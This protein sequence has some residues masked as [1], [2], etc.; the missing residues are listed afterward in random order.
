VVASIALLVVVGVAFSVLLSAINDL[1]G[2]TRWTEHSVAVLAASGEL[3]NDLSD[4]SSATRNYIDSPGR[5]ALQRFETLRSQ[6]PAEANRLE[7]MVSDNPE[8][9]VAARSLRTDIDSFITDYD[10]PLMATA[11]SPRGLERARAIVQQP[12]G[13]NMISVIR[14]EFER[15]NAHEKSLGLARGSNSRRHATRAAVI[16]V[17]ALVVLLLAILAAALLVGRWVV[18]PLRRMAAAAARLGRGDLS[19]RVDEGGQGEVRDLGRAFNRMAA[20]VRDSRDE[21]ETQN[22]ELEAQQAELEGALEQLAEEKEQVEELR[23]FIELISGE[24]DPDRLADTVLTELAQ[25]V[26]AP[27]GTLYGV[28]GE[29]GATLTCLSALGV[30][31]AKLPVEILPGEGFAGRA[32]VGREIVNADFGLEGLRFESFGQ[33]VTLN[34]EVHIP[35]V[36][37]EQTVGVVTL[38]RTGAYKLSAAELERIRYLA[39][40]AAVGLSHAFA[41]RRA[42]NQAALN[43]AVLDSAY[44]AVVSFD[45]RGIVT[46]WN[47]RAELIFGW[48]ALEALGREVDHLIVPEAERGWYRRSL[49]EFLQGGESDLLN[50]R[51]EVTGR[52]RGGREFPAE[53]ALSA[54]ELDG[55]WRFNAFI[56]DISERRQLEERSGRLFSI[57]LDFMATFTRDGHLR[58]INPA[59]SKVLGWTEEE[60]LGSNM[61]EYVHP[62]DRERTLEQA[63]RLELDGEA[64]AD[65]EN[66]WRCADGSY[67]WM[68]WSARYSRDE[69]LIYAVAKDVT[70]AKRNERFF[71][72]RLAVSEAL[73][74]ADSLEQDLAGAVAAAGKS[75]GWE[76]A[77]AWIPT[78]EGNAMRCA[79]VWGAEGQDESMLSAGAAEAELRPG[80]GIVG[81]AWQSG[82]PVWFTDAGDLVDDPSHPLA[83]VLRDAGV[84]AV[85]AVPL[86]GEEGVVAVLQLLSHATREAD[87]DSLRMLVALGE[88]VGHAVYRRL[89]RMEADRMKDE[90]L[91]LVS[92]ELRTPLTSIVGYLELLRDDEDE[93]GT[94]QGQRFLEVIERNATRLQ[95]LVDDVLFAARAEAGRMG[96][97]KRDIN[98][99]EVIE[100][101][102]TAAGPKAEDSGVLVH[103]EV[104]RVPRF[105]GDPDRLGQ[106]LDNLISNALKFTPP[107][108][109][110][111]V[112]LRNLGERARIEVR[113]T[114]LGMAEED[115]ARAFDRFFRASATRDHAPGVGLGLTIVKTIVEGHG[116]TIEVASREGVGTAFT[117]ELPLAAERSVSRS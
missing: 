52:H 14:S 8:Q 105:E 20:S 42:R 94:E 48:T 96:L 50:R 18:A 54:V 83:P 110:V 45:E 95:R 43:R 76:F 114:G 30:D 10:D 21:L 19:A 33:V 12:T 27:V 109:R 80:E 58:Q 65:F 104:E 74:D 71:Q 53:F 77:A 86:V 82:E 15:F 113:D 100:E 67:R 51:L 98:L 78:E 117:I 36:H 92:H 102:V 47:P 40:Q 13:R 4:F 116:G 31:L 17:S 35:L 37:G 2:S 61:L 84:R 111:D 90:F 87:D 88:Q 59:W 101:S 115:R 29:H 5:R 60:L 64:A 3:Q 56:H 106:A 22:R 24:S 7:G 6:L 11:R 25:Y 108:G 23:R 1:R 89:A 93:L 49:R 68:L 73:A 44:D 9:T 107:G 85:V 57:S 112:S 79:A 28:D 81:R 62:E 32:I 72:S 34:Q 63:A 16:G 39:A 91:A 26:G 70:D 41:L 46:A 38:G 103:S 66:R 69:Q 99:A 75:L 55:T 97:A